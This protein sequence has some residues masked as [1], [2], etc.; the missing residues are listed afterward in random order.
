MLAVK[1]IIEA[2]PLRAFRRD[3]EIETVTVAKLELLRLR[4]RHL[5]RFVG[6]LPH[7]NVPVPLNSSCW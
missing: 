7:N 5:D 6:Q 4:L 2:P 1:S 3:N